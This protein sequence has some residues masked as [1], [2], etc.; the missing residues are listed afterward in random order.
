MKTFSDKETVE[1]MEDIEK[2]RLAYM[3]DDTPVTEEDL[4]KLLEIAKK[5][6]NQDTSLNL[7]ELQKH[8]DVRSKLF[9][10]ITDACYMVLESESTT[11]QR[12]AFTSYLESQFIKT[13]ARQA[14]RTDLEGL[15]QLLIF[16]KQENPD[17]D[18]KALARDLIS[19]GLFEKEYDE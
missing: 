8:P 3:A 5:L 2:H 15:N 7:Y 9:E 12:M 16:A 1:S 11:A 19:I 4:P 10:H 13:L 14:S 17:G 6:Q 18:L